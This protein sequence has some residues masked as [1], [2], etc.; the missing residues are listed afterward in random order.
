MKI[1]LL[2]FDIPNK[3]LRGF[4]IT[5][6]KED[7][8]DWNVE[9]HDSDPEKLTE[10]AHGLQSAEEY[11]EDEDDFWY[12]N[13]D[14]SDIE[15]QEPTTKKSERIKYNRNKTISDQLKEVYDY[16]C[17]VCSMKYEAGPEEYL[18]Y[19]H[20]IHP[21]SEDGEDAISNLLVLCSICHDYFHRGSIQINLKN[22]LITHRMKTN[23]LNGKKIN[24]RHFV[25]SQNINYNNNNIYKGIKQ[26]LESLKE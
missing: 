16:T 7:E 6:R 26:N 2:P 18:I 11:Y 19:T 22:K 17:Q 8:E 9:W 25:S 12:E 15:D 20:H 24:I 10:L 5:P 21:L 14:E 1:T 13:M 3:K 4:D 23:N